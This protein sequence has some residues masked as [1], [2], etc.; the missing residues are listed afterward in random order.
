MDELSAVVDVSAAEPR[1]LL[2]SMASD[3]GPNIAPGASGRASR[4][5]SG[6][7]VSLVKVESENAGVRR[8]DRPIMT[9]SRRV[10]MGSRKGTQ[11]CRVFGF[12]AGVCNLESN[13]FLY[14][15]SYD[16]ILKGQ[17]Y[18]YLDNIDGPLALVWT[19]G[20]STFLH[21]RIRLTT[22]V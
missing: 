3:A 1:L 20:V 4:R 14:K 6:N 11:F 5:V 10:T 7:R 16:S 8:P 22:I 18:T 2:V 13:I 17:R 15:A 21:R 19:I 9:T 12:L